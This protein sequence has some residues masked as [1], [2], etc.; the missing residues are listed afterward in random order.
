MRQVEERRHL[1]SNRGVLLIDGQLPAENQVGRLA[2][3]GGGQS[4]GG[5]QG[6]GLV[7]SRVP[8][9]HG[10]IDAE[11]EAG[12]PQH[13]CG[14]VRPGADGNNLS[15]EF[16][17]QVEGRLHGV[18]V[19]GAGEQLDIRR[20]NRAAVPGDADARLRT[21]D[22]LDEDHDLQS[23]LPPS[24]RRTRRQKQTVPSAVPGSGDAAHGTTRHA[25]LAEKP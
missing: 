13:F 18:L 23:P 17:F 7:E 4:P 20:V 14:F 21:R 11:S 24:T 12:L 19:V 6:I 22:Q 9:E 3:A 15:A 8:D 25:T 10:T 1:R 16:L 5:P 2:M